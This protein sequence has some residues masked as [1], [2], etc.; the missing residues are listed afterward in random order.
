MSQRKDEWDF[1]TKPHC[2][3]LIYKSKS[4]SFLIFGVTMEYFGLIA[5]ALLGSCHGEFS[6]GLSHEDILKVYGYLLE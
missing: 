3:T 6:D 4:Y 5:L 2:S 1:E